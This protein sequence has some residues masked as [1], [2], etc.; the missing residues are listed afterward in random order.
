M[1]PMN[2]G[3]DEPTCKGIRETGCGLCGHFSAPMHCEGCPDVHGGERADTSTP[4]PWRVGSKVGRTIYRGTGPDDLIGV[5]DSRA[6]AELVVRLVNEQAG[7]A[8]ADRLTPE[9]RE[10]YEQNRGWMSDWL[11]TALDR[12]APRPDSGERA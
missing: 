6:D 9:E 12:L 7:G 3:S 5:M 4:G 10:L 2:E 1:E 8:R 11:T